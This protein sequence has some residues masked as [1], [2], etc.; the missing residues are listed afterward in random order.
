MMVIENEERIDP[1]EGKRKA[2]QKK[3]KS[4]TRGMEMKGRRFSPR[5]EKEERRRG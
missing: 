3:G 2:R 5:T 1:R 4:G